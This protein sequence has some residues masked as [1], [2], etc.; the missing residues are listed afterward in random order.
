MGIGSR[1]LGVGRRGRGIRGGLSS[2]HGE[3]DLTLTFLGWK[4]ETA[5]TVKGFSG[6]RRGS[7]LGALG[8]KSGRAEQSRA[9]LGPVQSSRAESSRAG[10]DRIKSNWVGLGWG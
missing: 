9:E 2:A 4:S 1:E 5:S 3:M 10:L 8:L 6:H 7:G